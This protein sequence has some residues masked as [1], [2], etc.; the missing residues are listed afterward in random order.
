MLKSG[1][2]DLTEHYRNQ[3]LEKIPAFH[4]STH[5]WWN[6][7][8]DS[9]KWSGVT[10]FK[11][12]K[13]GRSQRPFLTPL[14]TTTDKQLLLVQL[15]DWHPVSAQGWGGAGVPARRTPVIGCGAHQK[16]SGGPTSVGT[17]ASLSKR[18][19]GQAIKERWIFLSLTTGA[20]YQNPLL[21]TQEEEIPITAGQEDRSHLGSTR[22]GQIGIGSE[23]PSSPP[24]SK[25]YL[26]TPIES[27][28]AHFSLVF[29]SSLPF[30]NP[31]DIP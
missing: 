19:N 16:P 31:F 8:T 10:V 28:K 3:Q 22:S 18:N 21:M 6:S 25:A 17:D 29:F 15:G 23:L 12:A 11:H 7:S 13:E 1:K 26:L 20:W 24:S 14:L 5:L 2:G 9:I 27:L 30:P 4:I